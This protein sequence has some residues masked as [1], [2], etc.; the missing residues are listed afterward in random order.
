MGGKTWYTADV[1]PANAI[2]SNQG[3]ILLQIGR[4]ERRV[5][6]KGPGDEAIDNFLCRGEQMLVERFEVTVGIGPLPKLRP[7][8]GARRPPA[9]MQEDRFVNRRF[10]N[11]C[12]VNRF[13]AN[14]CLKSDKWGGY[15]YPP[16]P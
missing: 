11:R 14:R 3:T 5:M 1:I 7:D 12:L 4:F 2:S 9:R 16:S 6:G 15:R 10:V 8:I 13:L